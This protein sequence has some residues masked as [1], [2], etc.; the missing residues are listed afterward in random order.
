MIPENTS[1]IETQRLLRIQ[2]MDQL[3]KMGINPFPAESKRDFTLLYLSENFEKIQMEKTT[4]EDQFTIAGRIKSKRGSGK[5]GFILLEDESLPA[6]FQIVVKSDLLLDQNE[7]GNSQFSFENYKNLIEEGDFIQVSGRLEKTISGQDSLFATEI[8]ILTKSLR[9]LPDK[10]DYSNVEAR[11]LDRV[12]DFKMNTLDENGLSIREVAKLKAKYWHIWRDEMDKEGFLSMENPIFEHIP[13]GAECKPFTTFYNELDQEM[14]LRISLELPLKKLIAG[15][16]ERVYEIGRVFRNESTSPQHMQDFTF[17]EWYAA[18]TDYNWAAIFTKRVFQRIVQEIL[19]KMEQTD[20]YGNVI[21]W[22][23]W[24]GQ[25]LADENGWELVD[26]WPKINYFDA[27]RYFSGGKIDTENKSDLELLEICRE[28]EILD[29]KITD[30]TGTMLDKLWK[31]ARVNTVNPFFLINPPVELESLAKRN[32]TNPNLTER[33]Q[34]VAG[35]AEHGKA[36]SELNDPIDQFGR[37]QDQQ[38]ARDSGNDEAQFMDESYVKAMEYGMPPMSGFG[39]SDR[40]LSCLLGKSIKDIHNFPYVRRIEENSKHKSIFHEKPN[41]SKE[42]ET[43]IEMET[44]LLC[45]ENTYLFECTGNIIE[46]GELEGRNYIILDQTIFYP[47]GGGQ[48]TDN[49]FISSG[50]FT[51]SV[52]QCKSLE[53]RIY[54]FGEYLDNILP[55][56]D[57]KTGKEAVNVKIDSDVRKL[58]SKIHTAGHLLDIALKNVGLGLE[59]IK[60]YHFP[61][62]PYVEYLGRIENTEENIKMIENELVRLLDKKSKITM[63]IDPNQTLHGK[64]LRLMKIGDIN[65]GGCGGTHVDSLEKIRNVKI[66]KIKNGSGRA[67]VSYT[68]R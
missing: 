41:S 54:H 34:V 18:Y 42:I 21:N 37:F 36:F 45:L 4:L 26:G 56:E 9:P 46:I 47:Q 68:A 65:T 39:I 31:K 40:F 35:R 19:G 27:V 33:F 66:K 11:Y 29:V 38:D 62:G 67:R 58:H 15:G 48:K 60:G 24:C 55:I 51:F 20:Y 13:G 6:G 28:N 14:F 16:F 8:T 52:N 23:S 64:P 1:S 61:E 63:E 44:Q 3:K 32:R 10:M 43:L 7:G 57:E 2:K 59:S 53:N 22:G 12:A 25:T 17:I 50:N 49:G 30:G 5:I